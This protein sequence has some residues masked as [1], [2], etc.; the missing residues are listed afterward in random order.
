MTTAP[1][2][3][4]IPAAEFCDI[5]DHWV[6]ASWPMNREQAIDYAAQLGWVPKKAK[7]QTL[8]VNPR[9]TISIPDVKVA[10]GLSSGEVTNIRFAL[11]DTVYGEPPAELATFAADQF[12]LYYREGVTR[13][14]EAELWRARQRDSDVKEHPFTTARWSFGDDKV[15]IALTQGLGKV[16]V[17]FDVPGPE[18][19]EAG[20]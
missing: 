3:Q 17:N 18:G 11:T 7:G 16:Y 12:T 13:W 19:S 10:I 14:G 1:T 5:A 8:L 4:A 20:R 2:W 15:A 9:A 6:A